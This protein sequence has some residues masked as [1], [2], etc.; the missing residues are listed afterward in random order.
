MIEFAA[1]GQTL[2]EKKI[3]IDSNRLFNVE[4]D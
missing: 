4:W 3:Q 1:G 2:V